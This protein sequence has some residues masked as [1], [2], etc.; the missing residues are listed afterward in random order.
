MI[1]AKTIKDMSLSAAF[2]AVT[3]KKMVRRERKL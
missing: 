3:I 2:P 1:K